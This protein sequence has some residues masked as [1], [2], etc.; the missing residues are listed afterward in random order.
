MDA[1]ERDIFGGI[2]N[3]MTIIDEEMQRMRVV[4][5]RLEPVLKH[6]PEVKEPEEP[7]ILTLP[8]TAL[9]VSTRAETALISNRCRTIEDVTKLTKYSLQTTWHCGD[10]T[11]K[12]IETAL[13]KNGL[14]LAS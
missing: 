13:A 4:L 5:E 1:L 12:E 2:E 8:F 14:K 6:K 3:A 10:K 11:I 9:H 7:S